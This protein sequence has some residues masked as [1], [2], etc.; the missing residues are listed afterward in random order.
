MSRMPSVVDLVVGALR[1]VRV[2]GKGTVLSL[3]TPRAGTRTVR[4]WGDAVMTLDLANAIHRMIFMGSFSRDIVAW[5]RAL[6]PPGG[7]FLDVGANIGYFSLVAAGCV[8][9]R[10]RVVAVEPNPGA[11]EALRRHVEA[12][13]LG[14]VEPQRLALAD[15][16]GVLG[17]YAPP[18]GE[19]RDYNV[20]CLPRPDWT[21]IDVPC[22]RLDDCLDRWRVDRVDLMKMDV[23]GAEPRV[24]AGGATRLKQGVVR[25]LIVELNGPLLAEQGSSQGRLIEQLAA[26]GFLPAR[27]KGGRA[28]PLPA[29][30]LAPDPADATDHLFLHESTLS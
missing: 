3:I 11:F 7:T 12:N 28:V 13:G 21:A 26:L 4:V 27:L 14:Q 6:L 24:L 1:P 23:E 10:G 19:S 18:A 16:D 15:A 25:H 17:L 8:G 30:G 9:P 22:H 29:A 20:T 5:V 2:R